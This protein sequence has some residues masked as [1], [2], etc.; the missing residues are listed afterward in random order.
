MQL[1]SKKKIILLWLC[2]IILLLIIPSAAYAGTKVIPG[3]QS[4]GILLNTDG[5]TVIGFSPIIDKDGELHEP[6]TEA[7]LQIGDFIT[8]INGEEIHSNEDIETIVNQSGLT[9]EK[10]NVEYRRNGIKSSIAIDPIMC[11]ETSTWRIGVYVRDNLAGVGTLTYY[12]PS[13]KTFGALGHGINTRPSDQ[14]QSDIGSI[15]RASVQGIR[16]STAG[17]PGEKIGTFLKDTWQGKILKNGAFGV[18]GTMDSLPKTGTEHTMIETAS[19]EEVEV[20]PAVL[21][22]VLENETVE[23]FDVMIIKVLNDHKSGGKGMI[24]EVTDPEMLNTCGGIVQGMSGSPI[25]QNGK[26][27]GAISHVFVN[28]PTHGYGCHIQWMLDEAV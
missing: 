22:T 24:V 12:D 14:R 7:G 8:S 23:A 13:S 21:Y 3:G 27:I 11:S 28:D 17:T 2:I 6:A 4:I 10:C 19:P 9:N 15:I 16:A 20:G 1:I 25:I 18:Y 26:I 5:V